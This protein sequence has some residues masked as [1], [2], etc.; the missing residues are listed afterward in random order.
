M[1]SRRLVFMVGKNLKPLTKRSRPDG[2]RGSICPGRKCRRYMQFDIVDF[3]SLVW[4]QIFA[5]EVGVDRHL[6][7]SAST[8]RGD[9]VDGHDPAFSADQGDGFGG[10]VKLH[11]C[12]HDRGT[13]DYSHETP[14]RP[15]RC[16]HHPM[17]EVASIVWIDDHG[18]RS[19][20]RPIRPTPRLR[21]PARTHRKSGRFRV[22]TMPRGCYEPVES[23]RMVPGQGPDRRRRNWRRGTHRNRRGRRN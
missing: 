3:Q 22:G 7:L 19:V 18:T 9:E 16:A 21:P 13:S 17:R 1:A 4:A 11:R 8:D 6:K 23:V 15:V 5:F 2:H 10:D 14:D 20:Q 12:T